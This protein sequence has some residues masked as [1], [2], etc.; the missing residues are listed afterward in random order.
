MH[1]NG[2]LPI[3]VFSINRIVWSEIKPR[4]HYF[5]RNDFSRAT[6]SKRS[7]DHEYVT[8]SLLSGE[9]DK[10]KFKA[11]A[12]RPLRRMTISSPIFL[13]NS[14][15]SEFDCSKMVFPEYPPLPKV[16]PDEGSE[17]VK[18]V[19]GRFKIEP[20]KNRASCT[21]VTCEEGHARMS[22]I[23]TST[24][25]SRNHAP[26]Q[27]MEFA[28]AMAENDRAYEKVKLRIWRNRLRMRLMLN[29]HKM[30]LI[31]NEKSLQEYPSL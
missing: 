6:G 19:S 26:V 23:S 25:Y 9:Q 13:N 18:R 15:K 8:H 7:G 17:Q 5:E 10:S 22:C 29:Y 20:T 31:A 1:C 27:F 3:T 11:R 12:P 24:A 16:S 4:T 28:K 2:N 14:S 21:Y 30:M